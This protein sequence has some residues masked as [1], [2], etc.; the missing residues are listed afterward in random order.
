MVSA[1]EVITILNIVLFVIMLIGVCC[2]YD[3]MPAPVSVESAEDN[4][5]A[6]VEWRRAQETRYVGGRMSSKFSS[7][8]Y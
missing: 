6:F 4:I 3:P 2:V 8:A 1:L 7:H 5:S